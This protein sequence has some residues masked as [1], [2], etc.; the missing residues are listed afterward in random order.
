MKN[1]NRFKPVEAALLIALSLALLSGVWASAA[2]G[3]IAD[4]L[5]R[6]HVVAASDS[7]AEQAV[8]LAVRDSV[9]E[10]LGPRLEGAG[11]AGEAREIISANLGGV[12]RAAE[13]AAGGRV[14][15]VAL[16]EEYFPTRDYGSF[17]LPAGR[18]EALRVT[19][20]PG[21]GHNWW[22]VVFPPLCLSP[23]GAEAAFSALDEGT[24]SLIA[25]PSGGGVAFRFKLVELWGGLMEALGLG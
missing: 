1:T 18:Y 4:G 24:R 13:S 11:G 9:L 20:G 5:V 8:K 16:G 23:A 6:L 25:E 2:G 17:R 3:H 19:I 14:V 12:E 15:S 7:Q 10:Y 21:G 22:C